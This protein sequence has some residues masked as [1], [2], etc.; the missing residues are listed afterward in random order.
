MGIASVINRILPSVYEEDNLLHGIN[1]VVDVLK[2]VVQI[3]S[4]AYKHCT[5][6]VKQADSM[7]NLLTACLEGVSRLPEEARGK[8]LCHVAVSFYN[9]CSFI[10][11]QF[12]TGWYH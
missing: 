12:V 1:S 10:C 11:P 7:C 6:N 2:E 4:N 8:L 9:H 5:G 3:V